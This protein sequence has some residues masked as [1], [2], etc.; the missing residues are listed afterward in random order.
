MA[1]SLERLGGR[2][3]IVVRMLRTIMTFIVLVSLSVLFWMVRQSTNQNEQFA[4][5]ERDGV[6]YVNTLV[7]VELALAEYQTT[8]LTGEATS[9]EKLT[10]AIDAAAAIDVRYGDVLRTHE[11]WAELRA[12]IEALPTEKG[13]VDTTYSS[14]GET[15]DLL[16]ALVEKVRTNSQ[17]IRDPDA[18]TYFLQDAAAQELPEAIIAAGGLADLAI[19][20]SDKTV[21]E[22]SSAL[23]DLLSTSSSLASN[24]TDLSSNLR[25]TIDATESQTLG[26]NLLSPLDRFRQAVDVLIPSAVSIQ[27]RALAIDP[28]QVTANRA[29]VM[30]AAEALSAAMLTETDQ[31]LVTRLDSLGNEM[32]LSIGTV[33]LAALALLAPPVIWFVRR[34]KPG[35]VPP[36]NPGP[37]P[38]PARELPGQPF[39]ASM[40][41]SEQISAI[42]AW[43][44]SGA[45][46]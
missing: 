20:T 2:T 1:F 9:E 16:L 22:Q 19:I 8:V 6:A 28:A 44:Q 7:S 17:L 3:G 21:T 15:T 27:G 43:E 26:E 34:R 25:E 23:A 30:A 33:A 37:D 42:A 45:T 29:E 11:R 35:A 18:D 31:L 12:K 39:Q 40:L 38:R 4:T 10:R 14:F 13:D 41:S 24:A 36:Q 46:R 5:L 32:M